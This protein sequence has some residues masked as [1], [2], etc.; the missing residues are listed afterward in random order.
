MK[1]TSLRNIIEYEFSHYKRVQRKLQRIDTPLLV[2]TIVAIPVVILVVVI[3][4]TVAILVSTK[5]ASVVVA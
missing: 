5:I 2:D 3:V 4:V 1:C